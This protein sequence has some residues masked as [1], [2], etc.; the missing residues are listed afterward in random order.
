MQQRK[1]ASLHLQSGTKK[2]DE[3]HLLKNPT[4]WII[5]TIVLSI[6]F[7][8]IRSYHSTDFEVHRNWM[9]LTY[10]L[11]IDQWYYSNLSQW[12]LDYPPFFAYF[13]WLLS[14]LANVF[15]S[16]MLTLQ[17]D[18][19]FSTN[20]LYFQRITVIISDFVYFIACACVSNTHID[21]T[22]EKGANYARRLRMALFA[23]LIANP[24]L[25]LLDN[26]HFQY[27]GFLY[28]LF[29]LSL[30]AIFKNSFSEAA[31][32][33]CILLNFKHLYL[34]YVPAFA[35]F[36]FYIFLL[37]VGK[38]SFMRIILLGFIVTSIL[39]VSFGPFIVKGGNPAVKQIL[40]RLFPFQ[41]GLTHANWAPNFWA[42]Y[43]LLDLILAKLIGKL[44]TT[45]CSNIFWSRLLKKC[46]PSA[47][48]Y[49]RGLVRE[50][51]HSVLPNI[52][53]STTLA[54]IMLAL[55]LCFSNFF[56]KKDRT[57]KEIFLSS[58][59]LSA[60]AFFLF[61]WHVHEK[62]ILMVFFPMVL[63]AIQDHRFITP[64]S[65]ITIISVFAQFPLFFTPFEIFLKWAFACTYFAFCILLAN[66][67]WCIHPAELIRCPIARFLLKTLFIAELYSLVGHQMIFGI[68]N[69]DFLPSIMTSV[70]CSL[71]VLYSY[72]SVIS[73]LFGQDFGLRF[74]KKKVIR[75]EKRII[76]SE[77]ELF[78]GAT[79]VK[80]IAGVDLSVCSNEPSFAVVGFT[81][82]AYPS[83]KVV[84]C[85]DEV[86]LMNSLGG[87][88]PY[89]PEFFAIRE[90]NPLKR[91]VLRHISYCP[92]ID[93]LFIDSNGKWHSRRCGL[94]CHV[95]FDT[96]TPTIGMAKKLNV[97]PLLAS[98]LYKRDD[99]PKL[100]L[101][102]EQK[103]K[104]LQNE[105][106]ISELF[107]R[108]IP[109]GKNLPIPN[110]AI[111]RTKSSNTPFFVSSGYGI[112]FESAI[113][114]A[115][116]CIGGT[117]TNTNPVRMCDLLSRR[118]IKEIFEC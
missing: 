12:T 28:G 66:F 18:P 102:I 49:T 34:Y 104:E 11:P 58:L 107:A 111:L 39:G 47:P 36:Y 48:E 74:Q 91:A 14:Y 4:T 94:A 7:L 56:L 19:F 78:V 106:A 33:F 93:A 55:T 10:N 63:L 15:D 44:S 42:L 51:S 45:T 88:M 17:A 16:S 109:L 73:T 62:A 92:K 84:Y 82:L 76:D 117:S 23:L 52:T 26:V 13:E 95:G 97:F 29:L 89:L 64:L 115:F 60:Y 32:C 90:S 20:T 40:S 98:G 37:P 2:S 118:R 79:N 30:D 41:R 116:E 69:L 71:I 35:V 65:L 25:I 54:L 108:N 46:P 77:A 27:N 1:M 83:M 31:V 43:N 3:I 21:A 100:E 114:I 9:S 5:F 87:I 99:L 72:F 96:N 113:E 8:L 61:G 105:A 38:R 50:Y 68:N 75:K 6:K 70:A 86:V 101:N 80:H 81:I 24:A 67:L 57:P 59:A 22:M 103:C 53:S 110:V 85:A 112:S